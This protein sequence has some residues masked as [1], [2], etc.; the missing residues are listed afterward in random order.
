M[1][2]MALSNP[3]YRAIA[4]MNMDFAIIGYTAETLR[5]QRP[6]ANLA[7]LIL[8]NRIRGEKVGP[9]CIDGLCWV[10]VLA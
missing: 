10:S 1:L 8:A 2:K 5:H 6:P 3:L 4:D 7:A 9:Q